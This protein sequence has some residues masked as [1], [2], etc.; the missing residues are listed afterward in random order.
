MLFSRSV[1]FAL[2]AAVSAEDIY[3]LQ[4]DFATI[5]STDTV[6][7]SR[8]VNSY[9]DAM[10]TYISTKL[11]PYME[12]PELA[13]QIAGY[14]SRLYELA[15]RETTYLYSDFYNAWLKTT[16]NDD[17]NTYT[18]PS[19]TFDDLDSSIQ[20]TDAWDYS[21]SYGSETD[22]Y[23]A[24]ADSFITAADFASRTESVSETAPSSSGHVSGYFHGSSG[25]SPS[26]SSGSNWISSSFVA[27]SAA[28]SS[29][30]SVVASSASSASSTS[31]RSSS[32]G[33]SSAGMGGH[34][35]PMIVGA[36]LAGISVLLL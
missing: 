28:A 24:L 29:A 36:A 31:S 2:V 10:K 18:Y 16:T 19:Y 21:D 34:Q 12:D 6:A 11:A 33:S 32:T 8:W 9:G 14:E 22:M 23:G 5:A 7:F 26:R 35:A 3:Q 20:E 30:S 27:S 25:V 1:L 13:S 15:D 4:S 17:Y